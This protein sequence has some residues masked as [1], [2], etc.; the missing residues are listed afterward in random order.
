MYRAAMHLNEVEQC[1]LK[2]TKEQNLVLCYW[3][4]VCF[5]SVSAGNQ[6]FYEPGVNRVIT[7]WNFSNTVM[8]EPAG[9]GEKE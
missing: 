7:A 5:L 6:S 2:E 9:W 3:E 8:N 1:V 4:D